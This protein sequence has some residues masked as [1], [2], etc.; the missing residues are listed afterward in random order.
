MSHIKIDG[1]NLVGSLLTT[2]LERWLIFIAILGKNSQ[3]ALVAKSPPANPGDIDASLIPGQGRSPGRGH[4]NPLPYSC[5]ENPCREE[6]GG[7]QS[8]GSQRVRHG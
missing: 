2:A 4:S 6:P 3:V 8:M 7:L 1:P 5:L